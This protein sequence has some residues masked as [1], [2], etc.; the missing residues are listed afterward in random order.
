M[1]GY[2]RDTMDG[3]TMPRLPGP[4]TYYPSW[5]SLPLLVHPPPLTD[6][7]GHYP[8]EALLPVL[9]LFYGS[10]Q[11]NRG[12]LAVMAILP[13]Y[14]CY[15]V[16]SGSRNHPFQESGPLEIILKCLKRVFSWSD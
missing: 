4:G 1:D 14:N 11:V 2:T 6:Y 10:M 13:Q 12:L 7:L 8:N 16:T 5:L 15:C 9:A 3:Y